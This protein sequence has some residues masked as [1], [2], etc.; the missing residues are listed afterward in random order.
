MSYGVS[1]GKQDG[2]ARFFMSILGSTIIPG[3]M[4]HFQQ[5]FC[6]SS[7]T[8]LVLLK[9]H[10]MIDSYLLYMNLIFTDF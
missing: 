6:S 9:I 4:Q 1:Y 8:S 5:M 3:N 2:R 7:T 10:P